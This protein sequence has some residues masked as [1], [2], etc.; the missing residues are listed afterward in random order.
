MK[1]PS[2][3]AKISGF[4]LIELLV[5]ICL[6][7]IFAAVLSPAR[8]RPKPDRATM[9]HCLSNQRQITI[10]MLMWKDD[11]GGR[12]PW[13]ASP[14]NNETIEF[15]NLDYPAQ[16]FDAI[17]NY[18]HEPRVFVCP[19]DVTKTAATNQTQ[20]HNQNTSY[21]LELDAGTNQAVSILTGD[22]HLQTNHKPVKPGLFVY[23]N[24]L[25]MGWTREL[26]GKVQT[27]PI[28]VACFLDGHGETIRGINLN[29]IFQRQ[30]SITNRLA[31]P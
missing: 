31:V 14:T 10:C 27:A 9:I 12:F 28:G 3:R 11:N 2:A 7:A 25:E 4:T 26:H 13:Q 18:A 1:T 8:F 19:T 16:V 29:S 30:G 5:V 23:S 22:R 24:N 20:L 21:F 15:S 17:S 6:I